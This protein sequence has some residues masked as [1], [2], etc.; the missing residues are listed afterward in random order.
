M[1]SRPGRYHEV[2]VNLEVKEVWVGGHRYVICHNPEEEIRD[3]KRREE[4]IEHSRKELEKN[5]PQAFIM[6]RGLR[7]FVELK[8]GELLLSA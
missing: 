2:S 1:L 5:G 8:G 7:R 4:I 6:P 3:R